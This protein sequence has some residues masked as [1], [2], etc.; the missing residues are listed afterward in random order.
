MDDKYKIR[1]N[2][3]KCRY[4]KCLAVGMQPT[5]VNATIKRASESKSDVSAEVSHQET[6][7]EDTIEPVAADSTTNLIDAVVAGNNIFLH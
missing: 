5:L 4:D 6:K 3:K 2:C 7:Q 1:K